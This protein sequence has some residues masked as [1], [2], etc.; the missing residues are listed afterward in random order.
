MVSEGDKKDREDK[1]ETTHVRH[2]PHNP[3]QVCVCHSEFRA[4]LPKFNNLCILEENKDEQGGVE[5]EQE[6]DDV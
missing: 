6:E 4:L 5:D 2:V 3:L 1:E